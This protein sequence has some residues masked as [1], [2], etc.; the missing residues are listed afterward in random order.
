MTLT[1]GM[2]ANV[3]CI[4]WETKD[5]G[6]HLDFFSSVILASI[7]CVGTCDGEEVYVPLKGLLPISVPS[8]IVIGSMGPLIHE[9]GRCHEAAARMGHVERGGHDQSDQ[10]LH[11]GH[12]D[13]RY[14]S[15]IQ[16]STGYVGSCDGEEFHV[17]LMEA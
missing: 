17:F 13:A 7:M 15:V 8:D 16:A 6:Q 10:R 1:A 12:G 5:G 14:V 11:E 9:F 2:H 3:N 4:Y